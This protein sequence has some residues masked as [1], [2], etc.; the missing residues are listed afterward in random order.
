MNIEILTWIGIVLCL[1]QSAMFSG[2]NLAFFSI[3]RLRLEIEATNK[4]TAAV[5][6]LKLRKNSNFLLATIL[7]G[8]VA[9][10][11]LLTLLS[12]SVMAG[13]VAFMFSTFAITLLGEIIPQAYFSRNALKFASKLAPIIMVYQYILYPVTKPSALLL[14]M[15]VGQESVHYFKEKSLEHLIH[16]HIEH[17]DAEIDFVEGMG[18][19]NF[20]SLD[21]LVISQ[22]GE[23]LNPRSIIPIHHENGIPVF[24]K[25]NNNRQ[26]LFL[27]KVNESEEKWVVFVDENMDPSLVMDADGFLRAVLFEATAVNPFDYTHRPIVVKD[28][29]EKLGDIIH[30]FQ[31][32]PENTEDDVIDHDLV[33]LWSDKK[34]IITGADILGRLM[35]GI[36]RRGL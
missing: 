19:I 29:S 35:R 11:V 25:F 2:L 30:L 21:D 16:R 18:A 6:V 8:N 12:N 27:Q 10:N 5:K 4:N 33:L 28:S 1:G 22:E 26:D 32:T 17:E 23:F 14:N 31:V 36:V 20:L 13:I 3:P 34:Q 9:I 15:L 7:W 24:P